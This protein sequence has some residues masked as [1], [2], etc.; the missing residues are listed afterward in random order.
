MNGQDRERTNAPRLPRPRIR[1]CSLRRRGCGSPRKYS[2]SSCSVNWATA[3][4]ETTKDPKAREF[5]DV[6]DTPVLSDAERLLLST[7]RGRQKQTRAPRSDFFYAPP[8]LGLS[9]HAWLR[10][11]T[12]RCMRD[13]FLGGPLAHQH[14][15]GSFNKDLVVQAL[16]GHRSAQ[17]L[18]E[19]RG[20]EILSLLAL[21]LSVATRLRKIVLRH[22]SKGVSRPRSAPLAS[23]QHSDRIGIHPDRRFPR[24]LSLGSDHGTP[25][26]ALLPDRV[27]SDCDDD[28]DARALADHDNG[29]GLGALRRLGGSDTSGRRDARC[30]PQA[31]RRAPSSFVN[32]NSRGLRARRDVHACPG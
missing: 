30:D 12:D 29:A 17:S 23:S 27:P 20:K 22:L 21:R 6:V 11:R 7:C 14:E 1:S 8:Y 3:T 10:K 9:R 16:L 18:E 4:R 25:G 19:P 15:L 2:C 32:T 28:V 31:L 13:Y 24:T 26:V 5:S